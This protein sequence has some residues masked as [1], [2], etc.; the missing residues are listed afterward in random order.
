MDNPRKVGTRPLTDQEKALLKANFPWDPT[1]IAW[2]LFKGTAYLALVFFIFGQLL[3]EWLD[4]NICCD[5][6]SSVMAV[7][8]TIATS[9]SLY[10]YTLPAV[11]SEYHP[12]QKARREPY[13]KE[14]DEGI[15]NTEELVVTA[16]YELPEDEDEGVGFFLGLDDG[17]VLF[18]QG[19]DLYEHAHDYVDEQGPAKPP[20]FPSTRIRYSYGP[21]TGFEFSIEPLGKFLKPRVLKKLP[22]KKGKPRSEYP[23]PAT[24]YDGTLDEVLTRFALKPAGKKE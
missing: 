2:D 9:L 24:F 7:V 5:Q 12:D 3:W 14:F 18:V 13:K 1:R 23:A 15:A 21:K 17:R 19:Q 8:L 16:A 4:P 22:Y 20:S 10:F 11:R 6:K